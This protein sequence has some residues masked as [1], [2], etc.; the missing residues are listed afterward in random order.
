M[1][2]SPP[3]YRSMLCPY[4]VTGQNIKE[5]EKLWGASNMK[6]VALVIYINI[7]LHGIA[8]GNGREWNSGDASTLLIVPW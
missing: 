2:T 8:F 6:M 3:N 4:W 7:V 1:G 5:E